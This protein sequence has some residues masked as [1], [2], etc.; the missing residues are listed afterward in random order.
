MHPGLLNNR[1]HD[2]VS[3]W[4]PPTSGIIRIT[5][6]SPGLSAAWRWL[7]GESHPEHAKSAPGGTNADAWQN[8]A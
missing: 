6:E 4:D 3:P 1:A 2:A 8:L 5:D 7:C